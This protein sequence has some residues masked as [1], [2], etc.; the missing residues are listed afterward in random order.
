MVFQPP[1]CQTEI[2]FSLASF[3]KNSF[4]SLVSLWRCPWPI[5]HKQTERVNQCLETF[6]RCFVSATPTKWS[7]WIYLAE[8]WY[9]TSWHSSLGYSPFFVL[10]GHHPRHFG[11]SD[12]D[13]VQ[14]VP[15]GEWLEDRSLMNALVQQHLHQAQKRMKSQADKSCSERE[16]SIGDWVYLSSN[17]MCRLL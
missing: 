13:A 7:D 8:F 5:I 12:S 2:A 1:S 14:S 10:Y 17:H 16:F 4:D 15:L 9:N 6:L 11:V 3:G